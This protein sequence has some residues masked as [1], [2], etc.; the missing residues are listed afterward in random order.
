M[1]KEL[2]NLSWGLLYGK[3]EGEQDRGSERKVKGS[4]GFF[5]V[6]VGVMPWNAQR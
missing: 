4:N 3:V 2:K 6:K 5:P 1:S